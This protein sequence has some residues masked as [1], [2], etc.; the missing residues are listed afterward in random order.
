MVFAYLHLCEEAKRCALRDFSASD[1][2]AR[3]AVTKL[4]PMMTKSSFSIATLLLLALTTSSIAPA[5]A[6]KAAHAS[7]A[8][9]AYAAASVVGREVQAPPWSFACMNDQGPHECDEPMWV[10]GSLPSDAR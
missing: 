7:V 3:P 9:A 5:A 4:E 1:P 8:R 2:I 10:Y 6:K